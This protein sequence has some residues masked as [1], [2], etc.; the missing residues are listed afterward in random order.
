MITAFL[1]VDPSTFDDSLYVRTYTYS[2]TGNSYSYYTSKAYFKDNVYE[3]NL[4]SKGYGVLH[5]QNMYRVEFENEV[6]ER[7]GDSYC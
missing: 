6:F 3:A 5:I 1:A 7:N 2:V 4:A